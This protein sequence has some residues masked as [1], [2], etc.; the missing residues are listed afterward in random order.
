M[1][2]LKRLTM[3]LAYFLIGLACVC[4]Q[5][6]NVSIS[7]AIPVGGFTDLNTQSILKNKALKIVSAEGVATTE[8]G[9][10]AIVPEINILDQ[11]YVDGG[12]R[13]IYTLKLSTTFTVRNIMN[14]TVFNTVQIT[15]RGEGYTETEALRSAISKIDDTSNLFSNFISVSKKKILD[16]YANNTK[17]L[18]AKAKTLANQQLFDEALALMSTYPESLKGYAEVSST[19]STI[20]KQYQAHNC[21]QVLMEANAAY[22][23]HNYDEAAYLLATIDANSPCAVPAKSLLASINNALN[24]QYNDAISMEKEQLRSIERLQTAQLNAAK[25]V[26]KAYFQ[27]QNNYVFFW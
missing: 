9:A 15:S 27:R 20:F 12:M 22:S 13:R 10:I 1:L 24:K 11:D 25:E 21:N 26:A 6:E 7:V 3:T 17:A 16:Y 2:T 14:N 23:N 8:C 18:I 19:I 5:N 4:A